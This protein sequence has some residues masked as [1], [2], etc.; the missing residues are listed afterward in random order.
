MSDLVKTKHEVSFNIE[1]K[2]CEIPK[3]PPIKLRSTTVVFDEQW[4]DE[5]DMLLKEK[6]EKAEARRKKVI[7]KK[8]MAAQRPKTARIKSAEGVILED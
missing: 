1:F 2:S 6:Q 7:Q 8:I 5:R 3:L 4:K